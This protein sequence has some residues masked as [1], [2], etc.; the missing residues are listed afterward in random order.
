MGGA[1]GHPGQGGP[2]PPALAHC[3]G[4]DDFAPVRQL[5]GQAGGEQ[6]GTERWACISPE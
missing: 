5:L 3:S 4:A 2:L 1:E 6:V